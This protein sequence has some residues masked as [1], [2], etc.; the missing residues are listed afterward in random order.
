MS[1][2][3][4]IELLAF[5]EEMEK[6]AI[7]W[8]ALTRTMGTGLTGGATLG[9]VGG[10]LYGGVK[11][12]REARQQGADVGDSM[13]YGAGKGLVSGAKGALIGAGT[14]A[15]IGGAAGAIAPRAAGDWAA[16]MAQRK[17]ALGAISR[18]GQRQMHGFTGALNP[19]EVRGI[20][21]GAYGVKKELA[22]AQ[23]HLGKLEKGDAKSG[24]TGWAAEKAGL[25]DKYKALR[26]KMTKGKINRLANKAVPSGEKAEAM[27]LTSF[28]GWYRSAR[29]RGIG[30][31]VGAGMKE[32][33]HKL[34]PVGKALIYGYPA[35]SVAK[36]INKPGPAS[37]SNIGQE[38]GGAAGFAMA[39]FPLVGQLAA[40][41]VGSA[42]GGA[43]GKSLD[44]AKKRRQPAQV[45]SPEAYYEQ[46]PRYE[47]E[48]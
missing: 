22:D 6:I 36:E 7:P 37:L 3:T 29:D 18:T 34:G 26:T 32:Q 30:E 46:Q 45:R 4:D 9:G 39:P 42:V 35:Y 44:W 48:Y 31:T 12:Y 16:R 38:L 33:Y 43:A 23:K 27:G 2:F 8:K 25:G 28:P 5:K 47:G 15:A 41:G 14:G 11:G 19:K 40:S 24:V 10:G 1:R 20:R 21:G 13:L 17:G